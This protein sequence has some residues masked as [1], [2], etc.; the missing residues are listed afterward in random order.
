MMIRIGLLGF[1]KTGK[2]VA[3]EL[4]LDK[5]EGNP[6]FVEEIIR[7]LID[8]GIITRDGKKWHCAEEISSIE[9]P[10]SVDALI[11][12][13]IDRLSS[14]QQHVIACAAIIGKQFHFGHTQVP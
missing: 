11:R 10:D 7:S 6:F 3:R 5:S 14:N 12:A 2:E 1:G 4:I 13:R 9:L 8:S